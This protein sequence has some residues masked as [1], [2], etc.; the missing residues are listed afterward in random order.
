ML[1]FFFYGCEFVEKSISEEL[2]L[3]NGFYSLENITA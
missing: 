3:R 1:P 2:Q